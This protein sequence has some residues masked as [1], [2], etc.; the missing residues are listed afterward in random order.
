M[1][2][3]YYNPNILTAEEQAQIDER[4]RKLI[5][6]EKIM[7]PNIL[8]AEE[9][10]QIDERKRKLIEVEKNLVSE[11]FCVEKIDE[12]D[13]TRDFIFKKWANGLLGLL[14]PKS[15]KIGVGDIL[16]VYSDGIDGPIWAIRKIS[17]TVENKILL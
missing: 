10:A 15:A 13:E 14:L 12:L 2:D 3:N 9:Q 5:E 6:V 8:T 11:P 17:P 16:E 7:Y 1:T 4:N